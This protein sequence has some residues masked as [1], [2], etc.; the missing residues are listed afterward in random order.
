ME[1]I[2]S[3]IL[4]FVCQ[5]CILI[6]VLPC[7]LYIVL[8]DDD[9]AEKLMVVGPLSHWFVGGCNYT[10]LLLHSKEIRF[11]AQQMKSDWMTVTRLKDLQVML[12]YSKLGRY[13]V[14]FCA[15]F[16]QGG[17]LCFCALRA[18]TVETV[19]IGNDTKNVHLVPCT[20]SKKV[21]SF[22]TSPTNEI[23]IALQFLSGFIVN[24]T[25]AGAFSFAAVSAAHA[26]GQ[27]NVLTDWIKELLNRTGKF[28][29][30]IDSNKIG[31]IVNNHLR[32]LTFIAN[33]E[34]I[35]NKICLMELFKCTVC[36]CTLEYHILMEWA[37][38]DYQ[39]VTS[40]FLV[41]CSM[42]FN[43][44]IVCYIGEK[45]SEQ[46]KSIGET[47]YMTNWYYLPNK[48]ILDLI[49]IISRSHMMTK[50]TAGKVVPMSF[51]TFASVIKTG[52]AYLNVLRQTI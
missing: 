13:V 47:V 29:R 2:A 49:M 24:S 23:F 22:D 16:M 27:L 6:T 37:N 4:I 40:F 3:L 46:C 39:S 5:C 19:L 51:D 41:L 10:T 52:F 26:Y 14:V 1:K 7:I 15:A 50:I 11:C 12:K 18:F 32:I 43:M 21:I 33:I 20:P 17:V 30:K 31:I 9:I 38:H 48:D 35:M 45:L 8:D 34:D 28:D 42:S 36:I 44:F 25:A